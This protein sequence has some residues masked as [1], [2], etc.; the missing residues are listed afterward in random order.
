MK[1]VVE[2]T[3]KT[4]MM[5]INQYELLLIKKLYTFSIYNNID[6]FQFII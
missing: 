3:S 1:H 2:K 4:K 6:R 5:I